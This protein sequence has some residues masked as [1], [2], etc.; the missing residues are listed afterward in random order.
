MEYVLPIVDFEKRSLVRDEWWPV[1]VLLFVVRVYNNYALDQ[2]VQ[3]CER[4]GGTAVVTSEW[5]GT[6]WT[7]ECYKN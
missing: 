4:S 2:A 5:W 7:V 1:L 3:S 6:S